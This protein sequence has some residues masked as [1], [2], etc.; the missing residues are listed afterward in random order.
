MYD[1]EVSPD[2]I[3]RVADA[4]VEELNEWLTRPL[5]AVY[6]VV[7]IDALM[8]KIRDGMVANRPVY[9]AIGVDVDGGKKVLGMWIGPS[10][11]ESAK[12]WLSVQRAVSIGVGVLT[13]MSVGR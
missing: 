4:V 1:V 8:V 13:D 9:L 11:G 10:T 6:Q 3:S 7:F 5:D 2:L 12:F